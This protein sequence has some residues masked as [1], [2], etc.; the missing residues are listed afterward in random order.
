MNDCTFDVV[1][2]GVRQ[3]VDIK[4]ASRIKVTQRNLESIPNEVTFP[5]REALN[6]IF[7]KSVAD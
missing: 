7:Y 5:V 6:I 4:T 3:D 1:F 2:Y